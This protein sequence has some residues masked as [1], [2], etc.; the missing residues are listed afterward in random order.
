MQQQFQGQQDVVAQKA[1]N[2]VDKEKP[3]EMQQL[4]R[5]LGPNFAGEQPSEQVNQG[6]GQQTQQVTQGQSPQVQTHQPVM[7]EAKPEPVNLA[8]LSKEQLIMM[9]QQ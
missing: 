3:N 8:T 4:L 7:P 1:D 9:L 5:N 2:N 6:S